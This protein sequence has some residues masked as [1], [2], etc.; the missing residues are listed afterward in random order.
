MCAVKCVPLFHYVSTYRAAGTRT[1]PVL[2]VPRD[3]HEYYVNAKGGASGVTKTNGRGGACVP[4][5][6]TQVPL[7]A[8]MG[9][10]ARVCL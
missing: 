10:H 9:T 7:Y 1:V 4:S 3:T 6:L 8:R 2:V 5:T